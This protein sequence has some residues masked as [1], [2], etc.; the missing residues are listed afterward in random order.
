MVFG[1][2]SVQVHE[3]NRWHADGVRL[4]NLARNDNV[5][6]L[7]KIQNI[8]TDLQCEPEHFKDRIIF[9]SMHND[10]AW[11]EKGNTERCEH[12]SQTVASF[13]RKFPRGHLSFLE[14]G[15]EKK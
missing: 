15:S 3:S 8:M 12:N 13:A 11:R 5:G 6:L 14:L 4:E 9:M 1:K 10:I 2:Q 7:E